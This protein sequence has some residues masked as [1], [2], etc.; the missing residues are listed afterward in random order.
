MNRA[1]RPRRLLI[2]S[3]SRVR[4][5]AAVSCPGTS[6]KKMRPGARSRWPMLCAAI[7]RQMLTSRLIA[8]IFYEMPS[9]RQSR[10]LI[11]LTMRTQGGLSLC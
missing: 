1:G 10:E 11:G 8:L 5:L 4:V 7:V 2:W 3:R 9:S 6:R